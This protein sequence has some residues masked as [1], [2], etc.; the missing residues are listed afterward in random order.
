MSSSFCLW[1]RP[2]FNH[3][4]SARTTPN[5]VIHIQRVNRAGDESLSCAFESGASRLTSHTHQVALSCSEPTK[6]TKPR[7]TRKTIFRVFRVF[8][9]FV[10]WISSLPQQES[11]HESARDVGVCGGFSW[12]RFHQL[13]GE[14][15][16]ARNHPRRS[17]TRRPGAGAA[18]ASD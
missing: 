17:E 11:R 15:A 13:L 5:P 12:N 8:V 4:G 18:H 14:P 3:R 6:H 7:N 9:P 10:L 2:S 16:E 1:E